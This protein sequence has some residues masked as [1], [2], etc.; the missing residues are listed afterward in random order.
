M[1]KIKFH[2]KKAGRQQMY[3]S[4]SLAAIFQM[5][6]SEEIGMTLG[7]MYNLPKERKNYIETKK[8]VIVKL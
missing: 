7:T 3:S 2:E 1:Y 6:T 4:S 8:C 5:F